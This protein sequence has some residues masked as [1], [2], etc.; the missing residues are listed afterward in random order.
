MHAEELDLDELVGN[1]VI[2]T[3]H[4]AAQKRLA[5]SVEI[6]GDVPRRVRGDPLRLGQVL[7]NPGQQRGS[8]S[9]IAGGAVTL[10]ITR[11]G[12]GEG[13]ARQRRAPVLRGPAT[14]AS[15]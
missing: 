1:V 13:E 4:D 11:D 5:W 8:S 3:G 9:P 10:A 2:V 6:A 15:A 14:P 12:G 7:I